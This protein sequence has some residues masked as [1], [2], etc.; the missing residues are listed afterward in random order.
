MARQI[1][2][3]KQGDA[4]IKVVLQNAQHAPAMH[5]PVRSIYDEMMTRID[6]D[7][8]EVY[9]HERDGE[10]K[11]VTWVTLNSVK[12]VFAYN[13]TLKCVE[14]RARNLRGDVAASFNAGDDRASV[15]KALKAGLKKLGVS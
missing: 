12:M 3:R 8:D 1:S 4:F 14:L 2:S 6:F 13:Y 7:R 9:V 15:S 10:M 5:E 11:R